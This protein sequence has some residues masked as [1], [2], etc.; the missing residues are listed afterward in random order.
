MEDT[1]YKF[2]Q[3]TTMILFLLLCGT[4]FSQDN[5]KYL[6]GIAS[7]YGD[8]F[9]GQKTASGAAYSSQSLTAGHTSLPFG[10]RVEVENLSN[11]KKVQVL[12]NDRGPFEKNRVINLSKQAAN[13][14]DFIQEG[15]TFVKITIIEVGS[16]M[17]ASTPTPTV[18]GSDIPQNYTSKTSDDALFQSLNNSLEFEKDSFDLVSEDSQLRAQGNFANNNPNV[19]PVGFSSANDVLI[20]DPLSNIM[21]SPDDQY[22]AAPN[23]FQES[24]GLS[25]RDRQLVKENDYSDP[26]ANLFNDASEPYSFQRESENGLSDPTTDDES[27]NNI[28]GERLEILTNVN[29]D[30]ITNRIPL[31]PTPP[32]EEPATPEPPAEEPASEEPPAEE[33]AS[34]YPEEYDDDFYDDLFGDE[35]TSDDFYDDIFDDDSYYDDS[36]EALDPTNNTVEMTNF[37]EIT[38]FVDITN[39]SPAPASPPAPPTSLEEEPKEKHYI[40]QIGAFKEQKNALAV[41]EKL[42]ALGYNAY[43]TDVKLDGRNLMR[44]RVGYFKELEESIQ[45]S[46]QLEQAFGLENR[47]I[48]V[49]YSQ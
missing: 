5:S 42:R 31:P 36:P 8:Q 39:E 43:I 17:P 49:D 20:N 34:E 9:E 38:N 33:P 29:V 11:G 4:T 13:I 47:I 26:F 1:M 19:N 24:M 2:V 7:W 30:I 48:Q 15:S 14:L 21:I 40:I 3:S 35:P 10:T 45:M 41:Y 6:Y 16:S 18:S 46:T 23:S 27:A 22:R 28:N 37:T 32:A 12:I 44:V 25:S